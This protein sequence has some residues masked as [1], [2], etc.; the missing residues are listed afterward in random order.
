MLPLFLFVVFL[1]AQFSVPII[2][3]KIW[4]HQHRMWFKQTAAQFYADRPELFVQYTIDQ[5]FKQ[6]ITVLKPQKEFAFRGKKYDVLDTLNAQE[7]YIVL[8][9]QDELEDTLADFVA[10]HT[11]SDKK[12]HSNIVIQDWFRIFCSS[13]IHGMVVPHKVESALLSHA[14]PENEFGIGLHPP[15]DS[16][17]PQRGYLGS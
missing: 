12:D 5:N 3:Y 1:I 14:A 8:C 17:P 6:E 15:I 16:P 11:T 13:Q 7:P 2:G 10:A 9:V 4:H